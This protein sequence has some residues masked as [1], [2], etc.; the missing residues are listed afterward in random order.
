MPLSGQIQ[1]ASI[2]ARDI[3]R[4]TGSE[5]P[6][7]DDEKTMADLIARVDKTMDT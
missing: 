2:R 6:R 3:A 4:L 5:P 1:I 7:D